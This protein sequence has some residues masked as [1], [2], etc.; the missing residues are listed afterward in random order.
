MIVYLAGII[1]NGKDT[2]IGHEYDEKEETLFIK[3]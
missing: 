3:H 1:G 2:T